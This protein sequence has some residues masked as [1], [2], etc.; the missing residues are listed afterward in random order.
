MKNEKHAMK[1][2]KWNAHARMTSSVLRFSLHVFHFS[3]PL[4][5]G[6]ILNLS[7]H[8]DEKNT[9]GPFNQQETEA[10]I[11]RGIDL[12]LIPPATVAHPQRR[13]RGLSSCGAIRHRAAPR[14][15]RRPNTPRRV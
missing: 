9:S 2:E 15:R 14:A 7:V 10:G 11:D 13:D 12:L 8:P 5:K 4:F 1:N 6:E 3:F